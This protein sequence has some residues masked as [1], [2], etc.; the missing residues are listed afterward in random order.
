MNAPLDALAL[1]LDGIRAVEANA[2]TGKTF[3]I[4]TL[5]LRLILSHGLM[6]AEI[7]V[8]TF[9]RAAT[10]ELS[11]R[12]REWLALAD[13]LLQEPD[14]ASPRVGEEGERAVLRRVIEQG[15]QTLVDAG[16]AA[17][18]DTL[19]K[20]I[21]DARLALDTAQISTL[22]SFCFRVLTEFGFEAGQPLRTREAID[23]L[24][25]LD[26]EIIR[27]FWRR[28]S[29]DE[30]TAQL[31]AD[32]WG[33]A[34]KL[35]GQAGHARWENL[36]EGFDARV[37]VPDPAMLA[38]AFDTARRRIAEWDDS[39]RAAFVAEIE[40]CVSTART[41]TQR[42]QV[43]DDLHAWAQAA[44]G[45]SALHTFDAK[46]ANA[47]R[48]EAIASLTPKG[49]QPAG[50]VFDDLA[51]LQDAW[52][53][54]GQ[55][56]TRETEA[57]AAN[58]LCDARTM[59]VAE[60]AERLAARDL[61]SHDQAVHALHAAL[62]GPRREALI[63]N[64]R[65]RWR[66]ALVDEFQDT[67]RAQWAIV[68]ALFGESR[69]VIVGDPKQ[70][71]YGF[72]GGDVFAWLD[73]FDQHE[74]EALQ[75]ATSYRSGN[76]LCKAVNA[77]FGVDRAF[78]DTA[79]DYVDV[80]ASGRS[81]DRAVLHDGAALPGLRFWCLAADESDGKAKRRAPGKGAVKDRIEART[82]QHIAW[83][84]GRAQLRGR[85][86]TLEA[87]QPKHIAVLVGSNAEAA[88]MQAALA[89][90]GIPA[91]SNLQES[92]YA[93]EEA[94]DLALLLEAMA[95][96]ADGERARAAWASRLTGKSATEVAASLA[97]SGGPQI[98]AARWAHDVRRRGVL[99]WL[100]WMLVD[101]APRLLR[102]PGG[103]R[104]V[105]NY[106]QLAELLEG[107][108]TGDADVAA[109]AADFARARANAGGPGTAD[110]DAARLRLET[111]ADA[112]TVSTVHAAKGL[113]YDVVF[114][115]YACAGRDP[116]RKGDG[117]RMAWFHDTH[118]QQHLALG[119]ATA[120]ADARTRREILAEEI[121]KLYVAITRAR[122][123]CV[124]PWGWINDGQHTA[125]HH[126]LHRDGEDHSDAGCRDAL[127][128][129]AASADGA[130]DVVAWEDV[131]T[132]PRWTSR[133]APTHAL[134]AAGFTR[135]GLERDWT[136]WSFSRL[137]RGNHAAAVDTLPGSGD[138]DAEFGGARFGSAVHA[139]FERTDFGAWRDASGIPPAQLPLIE[140]ALADHGVAEGA[141]LPR[142]VASV[143]AMLHDALNAPLPCGTRLADVPPE[144]RRAEIEFHLSLAPS[145]SAELYDL[146]HAHD[147]Q[148]NRS[149]V[150]AANLAGLLTGKIDLTFR[151]DGRYWIV[152][153]KTNRC[154][155]YDAAALDAEI[156]RHDY[157][158]QW[159]IY[160]LA[161]HRWLGATLPDYDYARDFGGVFYLFVR[162]I[163]GGVGVRADRP[164]QAL[165][166]A[167]DAL[168]GTRDKVAA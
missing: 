72:R 117:V 126:L 54:V 84:L 1:P 110:D 68:R 100:H 61:V 77:L 121:R 87:L 114:L 70:A 88:S 10:A 163:Q 145:A 78:V 98:D 45:D 17:P 23:D 49:V 153:W 34:E 116:G 103:A 155:P 123:L 161:L 111:D 150:A 16:A 57:H 106:L 113:E 142:A 4:A 94:A 154:A 93:S 149:G 41:R 52:L 136:V 20:R 139:V 141:A 158:L 160:T 83:L 92:V 2:G 24:R 86:G 67:D 137:V 152:D 58:L 119:R 37:A 132:A 147:Y 55:R 71:I 43:R 104:R 40:R 128:A 66:A 73:A 89:R 81:R 9:T 124:I 120:E 140:R 129:L 105:A 143:G 165:I 166:E 50:K 22:H 80:A 5:Y 64:A 65:K 7:V 48:A 79:I 162:G 102:E 133:D 82:V 122:A 63:A 168:F 96:P 112:V 15:L 101:A 146:L 30:T 6:P 109:L 3:T 76:A 12:L 56:S 8:A 19:H 135:V 14:P 25:A 74:G 90:A 91:A 108:R 99:A 115:P 157:D 47:I 131:Q 159:L 46:A 130:I 156:G 138:D 35:A 32:T 107:G 39:D 28:A 118:R 164:P 29:A 42:I 21:D 134:A 31:L 53:A 75:L 11:E 125:L 144:A 18:R 148:L 62:H 44:E 59:L 95:D 151:H 51:T 97:D 33:T 127:H 85:D 38:A 27:D 36:P 69:L 60:R 26:L 167:M 13:E